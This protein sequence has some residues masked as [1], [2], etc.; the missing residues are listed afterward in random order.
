[1]D[2]VVSLF[3]GGVEVGVDLFEVGRQGLVFRQDDDC[4]VV[5]VGSLTAFFPGID[6]DDDGFD[7]VA[8]GGC[9]DGGG[10]ALGALHVAVVRSYGGFGQGVL[11]VVVVDQSD[12]GVFQ[13]VGLFVGDALLGHR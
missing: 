5:L 7:G 11:G 1:M 3:D 9:Q 8:G 2:Y 12:V 13:V 10:P 4:H 6:A